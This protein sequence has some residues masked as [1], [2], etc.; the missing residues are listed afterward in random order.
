[1]FN[2]AITN[3]LCQVASNE[4]Q[5]G[6]ILF[7][8]IAIYPFTQ[9]AH[10]TGSWCSHVGFAVKEQGQWFVLESSVPFVRKTPLR[11]FIWRTKGNDLAIRRFGS[12]LTASE[13]AALKAA[14]NA[15]MGKLYHTGFDYDSR[16]QFCSKFVHQVYNEALGLSLGRVQSLEELLAENP[17]ANLSF[18]RS[19]YFGR[20]PWSRR[21]LT[22]HSLLIDPQL[23]TVIDC[24]EERL[25]RLE[26]N[27]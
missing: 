1:M 3:R 17:Q 27:G 7:I 10:G 14:A 4:L 8:S 18:W 25:Q 20:I 24:T 6:D 26:L 11:K 12:G 19:W 22:P 23:Q 15:H 13:V 5:E 9:V 21:T 2:R 16:R